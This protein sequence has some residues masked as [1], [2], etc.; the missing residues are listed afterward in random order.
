M[1][2]FHERIARWHGMETFM[3]TSILAARTSRC[4]VVSSTSCRVL[5][6]RHARAF[7]WTRWL[8]GA[9][10]VA[11][12]GSA[13]S[14]AADVKGPEWKRGDKEVAEFIVVAGVFASN[15]DMLQQQPGTTDR[16]DP[17]SYLTCCSP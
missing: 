17:Y 13:G 2:F 16:R 10:A 6:V 3:I 15:P 7:R 14:A 5:P 9:T 11:L 1:V 12:I 4:G 8:G